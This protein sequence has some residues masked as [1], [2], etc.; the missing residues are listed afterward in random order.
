MELQAYKELVNQITIGEIASHDGYTSD[1]GPEPLFAIDIV[2][3]QIGKVFSEMMGVSKQYISK[4][5][6]KSKSDPWKYL[7]Y[8]ALSYPTLNLQLYVTENADQKMVLESIVHVDG[9]EIQL[10]DLNE[11]GLAVVD[12]FLVVDTNLWV[13]PSRFSKKHHLTKQRLNSLI[14]LRKFQRVKIPILG[15]TLIRFLP[16][17][18]EV[19]FKKIVKGFSLNLEKIRSSKPNIRVSHIKYGKAYLVVTTYEILIGNFIS[20]TAYLAFF[21]INGIQ[22]PVELKTIK[23]VQG[24]PK[25]RNKWNKV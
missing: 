23:L 13:I 1:S 24:I 5:G 3:Y 12:C 25:T 15:L 4:C 21:D 19:V 18:E 14:T 2:H 10:K 22:F 16:E 7:E 20:A 9:K 17:H 11:L 6:K 8:S